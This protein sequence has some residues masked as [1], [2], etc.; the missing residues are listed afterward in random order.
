MGAERKYKKK[1]ETLTVKTDWNI[2]KHLARFE[3]K[4]DQDGT[5]HIQVFPHDT[6]GDASEAAPSSS[7]FFRASFK[8]VPYVPSFP[9][10]MGP[11]K[12]IGLEPI[13]VHPP[14]PEGQGSQG[15]LPG[16]DRW[17]AVT[18]GM[19]SSRTSIGWFDMRQA[20]GE[21]NVVKGGGFENFWPGMKRWHLGVRMDDAEID[22][23]EG[24]YWESPKS[25]L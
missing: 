9:S 23:P 17:C 12:Y 25:V 21:G 10:S 1:S 11:L 16:T 6:T 24:R 20:D 3:F 15:E 5:T 8:T 4:E 2:P 14:L 19:S 18:P 7:P 22:F 13:L